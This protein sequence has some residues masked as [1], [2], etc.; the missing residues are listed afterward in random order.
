MLFQIGQD[1]V[2]SG[3]L[4]NNVEDDGSR[5]LVPDKNNGENDTMI[6]H[7]S[8]FGTDAGDAASMVEIESNL[9]TMVI[10]SDESTMKRK[11]ILFNAFRKKKS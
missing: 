5:T 1:L 4:K 11:I 9:G 2:N 7:G 6:M 10:N 3:T 8:D